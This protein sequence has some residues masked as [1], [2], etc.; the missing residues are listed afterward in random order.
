MPPSLRPLGKII[1]LQ[2]QR[3][4]LKVGEKPNRVYDPAP[5]LAMAELTLTPQGALVPQADGAA[6][7]D[8]HHAAH[9]QTRNSDNVNALSLGFTAHYA[10]MR[11]R[12]GEHLALGCAGE[13]LLVEAAGRLALDEL[14]G[15]VIIRKSDGTQISLTNLMIAA[16]C[17]P[18]A[19][20]ALGR[21]VDAAALKDALQFLDAGRRGFYCRLA[22][23]EPVTVAV[24]DEVLTMELRQ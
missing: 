20:Y 21:T 5:L 9:P 18:F 16:P 23:T 8:V 12:F 15:G 10:D 2:I 6:L 11:A 13:N 4:P 19:G 14:A 22:Q 17:R 1:R 24:G 7:I 3:A